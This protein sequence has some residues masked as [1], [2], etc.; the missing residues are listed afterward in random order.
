MNTSDLVK[1]LNK[2]TASVGLSGYE[3]EV[4]R[5]IEDLWKPFCDE[6]SVTPLGSF[7]AL[8]KGTAPE[9][10]PRLMIT[11]HMDVIGLMVTEI[12]DGFLRVTEIGGVDTR[13]LP[14]QSV[15]IHG[16][17]KLYGVIVQPPPF[18]LPE[19]YRSTSRAVPLEH[20]WVDTGLSAKEAAG[21]VQVGDL[22]TFDSPLMELGND[23]V[24]SAGLDNRASVM[25][26]TVCLEALQNRKTLWDV[27]A[28]ASVQEE[29][30]LGGGATSAFNLRPDLA[31]IVDCTWG[32]GPGSPSN[33]T[34]PLG[35]AP[36]FGWGPTVHP[37]I[38]KTFLDIAGQLEMSY[39]TEPMP[40]R[41]GT[42]TDRLQTVAQ[43]I[44]TMVICLPLRYMHTPVEIISV[45][46][47]QRV[48]RLLAEFA[49]SLEIDYMEKMTWDKPK[50]A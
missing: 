24:C 44:P 1:Q 21:V 7:H 28:V 39:R 18:L 32:S 5:Q 22:V 45:K 25:A 34:F 26:L 35:K 19:E 12:V 46:D 42:D 6:V 23:L 11:A 10:R 17:R 30:T 47:I 41:S 29:E 14:G 49:S 37:Y 9:P 4:R 48:G 50:Q 2:L 27:W 38:Y 20:L 31:V 43:G 16:R 40:G 8:R 33:K 36:V 3:T 15:R 13:I